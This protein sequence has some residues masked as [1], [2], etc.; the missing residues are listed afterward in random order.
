MVL[1]HKEKTADNGGIK[2]AY[3]AYSRWVER[4]GMEDRLPGID[5]TPNQLFW[6]S[7][8]QVWCGK[9]R[10][11]YLNS[12]ILVDPHSPARFRIIG[13]FS[14]SED[15]SRDFNCRPG[16]YMNPETKCTVW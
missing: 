16:S 9:F 12:L 15:F 6:I 5:Y 2:T 3:K 10:E 13:P 1:M 8:A 14:N 11:E 4:H 7:N